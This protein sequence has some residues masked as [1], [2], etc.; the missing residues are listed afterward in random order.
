M[1]ARRPASSVGGAPRRRSSSGSI[2]VDEL[3]SHVCVRGRVGGRRRALR[4][5]SLYCVEQIGLDGS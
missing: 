3:G 1:A 4:S 2:A 5:H